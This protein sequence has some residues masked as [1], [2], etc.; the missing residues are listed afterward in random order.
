MHLSEFSITAGG[1]H[2][3]AMTLQMEAPQTRIAELQLENSQ[4]RRLVADLLLEQMKLEEAGR[5]A[6][7]EVGDERKGPR[8]CGVCR[9]HVR[10]PLSV[11]R[12]D[13]RADVNS[14]HLPEV[15]ALLAYL[16]LDPL[17]AMAE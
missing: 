9:L 2:R 14:Q 15:R 16:R 12:L 10:I 1:L 11:G 5:R 8:Y 17:D 7:D 3:C 4:L 6:L 13:R